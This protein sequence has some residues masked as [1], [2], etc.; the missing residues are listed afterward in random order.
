M[1]WSRKTDG[2]EPAPLPLPP[3]EEN[4]EHYVCTL[5]CI[6]WPNLAQWTAA[7]LAPPRQRQGAKL[8]LT[9]C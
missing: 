5:S 2:K 3:V 9:K 6:S 4:A 1:I 7:I 8:T